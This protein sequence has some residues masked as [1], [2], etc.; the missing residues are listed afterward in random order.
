MSELLDIVIPLREKLA[1][2]IPYPGDEK[3][4]SSL[5][6][7]PGTLSVFDDFDSTLRVRSSSPFKSVISYLERHLGS[8]AFRTDRVVEWVFDNGVEVIAKEVH[9]SGGKGWVQVRVENPTLDL[10]RELQEAPKEQE[11]DR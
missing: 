9:Q 10:T 3:L 5:Q 8:D 7:I 11:D 4:I 2:S 1:K 6:R